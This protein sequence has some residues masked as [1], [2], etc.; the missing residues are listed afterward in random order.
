M[1]SRTIRE[2]SVGLLILLGLGL[3]GLLLLWLRGLNL[4]ARSYRFVVEFAAVGGMQAGAPV[5]YRGVSVGRIIAIRPGANAVEAEVEIGSATLLMPRNSLIEANQSGLIG[6]T[7]IDITPPNELLADTGVTPFSANCDTSPIV[8]DGTRLQGEIGVSFEALIRSTVE[9]TDLFTDPTF[10]NDI[11][12]LTRNTSNA[13]A[14]IANLANEVTEL[15]QG[16]EIQLNTLTTSASTTA[17]AVGQAATQIGLTAAQVNSLID[18]NRS[19]LVSTLNNLNQASTR[20]QSVVEQL[21]PVVED[22]ELVA[23]L[24]TLS[25]NAAEASTNLRNLSETVGSSENIVLLQQTLDSARATFQNAQKI[26][27][28][29]DELTGDPA[30]RSN[31]RELVNGLSGLVS[32]TQQLHQQTELARVLTPAAI[33]LN[34]ASESSAF[35][36]PT[37]LPGQTATPTAPLSV[38]DP[39]RNIRFRSVNPPADR[40]PPALPAAAPQ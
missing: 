6:E 14:N 8:C 3:F 27:A 19:T 25:A 13:A 17:N 40:R 7:S 11:R 18:T 4:G 38:I 39:D 2:G 21:A 30:F 22:G 9:L 34:Q 31:L 36:A 24:Q 20:L 16:V 10:F 1:R 23:N 32:S 37:P 12:T 28:D 5:R 26:T 35:Q 29:L 15:T 33:A